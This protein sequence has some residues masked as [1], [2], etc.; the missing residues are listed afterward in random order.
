MRTTTLQAAFYTP[1]FFA[2]EVAEE[3]KG[4]KSIRI[5][6]GGWLRKRD[7]TG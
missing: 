6:R 5:D 7:E 1:T 2:G 4:A 3:R